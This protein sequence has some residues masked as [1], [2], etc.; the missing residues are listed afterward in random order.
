[1]PLLQ[2]SDAPWGVARIAAKRRGVF[3]ASSITAIR[4]RHITRELH[5]AAD[6]HSRAAASGQRRFATIPMSAS[7][8]RLHKAQNSVGAVA[9]ASRTSRSWPGLAKMA[10]HRRPT[11]SPARRILLNTT[12]R[13]VVIRTAITTRGTWRSPLQRRGIA[14]PIITN[15]PSAQLRSARNGHRTSRPALP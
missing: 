1:M 5:R 4:R 14:V 2:F 10:A 3:C 13:D 9:A 6:R 12:S 11:L 15:I 7:S 8:L